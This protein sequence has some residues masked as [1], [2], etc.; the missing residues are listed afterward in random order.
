MAGYGLLQLADSTENRAKGGLR[1]AA[2]FEHQRNMTNKQIDAGK[3]AQ[4]KSLG[5]TV[6]GVAA[7]KGLKSYWDAVNAADAAAVAEGTAAPEAIAAT[8]EGAGTAAEVATAAESA[9]AAGELATAAEGA[10]AA[11]ELATAAEGA[12]LATE[13]AAAASAGT[14]AATTTAA[15]TGAAAGTSGTGVLAAMGPWGWAAL[16]TLALTQLL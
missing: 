7:E 11:S 3:E 8:L 14:T 2:D 15:T 6:T 13:A 16:G 9:A 1:Q 5:Y 12:A 4:N 10:V